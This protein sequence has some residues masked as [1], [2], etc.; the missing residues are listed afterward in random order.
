MYITIEEKNSQLNQECNNI[1]LRSKNGN[2]LFIE[3]VDGNLVIRNS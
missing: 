3:E 2:T 1:K